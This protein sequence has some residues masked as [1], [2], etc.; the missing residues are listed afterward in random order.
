MSKRETN[1]GSKTTTKNNSNNN[2]NNV[3]YK[4]STAMMAGKTIEYVLI[5]DIIGKMHFVA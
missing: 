4:N 3:S 5:V 2:K 1:R